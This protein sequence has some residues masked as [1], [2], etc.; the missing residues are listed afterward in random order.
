VA[1]SANDH[2]RN[3]ETGPEFC[4]IDPQIGEERLGLEEKGAGLE[5]FAMQ[6]SLNLKES[7]AGGCHVS[8]FGINGITRE[9]VLESLCGWD[10]PFVTAIPI[11]AYEFSPQ[12][13]SNGRYGLVHN[14]PQ[15]AVQ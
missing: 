10:A 1:S 15:M 5:D 4:G 2:A 11:S 8:P 6:A 7:K 9:Q 13:G 12:Y 14:L 3:N